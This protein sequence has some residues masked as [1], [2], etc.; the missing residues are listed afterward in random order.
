ME[1][2]AREALF[3][4]TEA[5]NEVA[6]LLRT[7]VMFCELVGFGASAIQNDTS[8]VF[9]WQTKAESSRVTRGVYKGAWW[10]RLITKSSRRM[11]WYHASPLRSV[12]YA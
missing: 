11:R 6:V 10:Q 2:R 3:D 12:F 9:C 5:V 7:V 8:A 1:E 4:R